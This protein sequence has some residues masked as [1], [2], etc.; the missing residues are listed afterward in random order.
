[1]DEMQCGNNVMKLDRK[2]MTLTINGKVIAGKCKDIQ[3]SQYDRNQPYVYFMDGPYLKGC[4]WIENAEDHPNQWRLDS[5]RQGDKNKKPPW[6]AGVFQDTLT[7]NGDELVLQ[8]EKVKVGRKQGR[9]KLNDKA[10]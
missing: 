6:L 1:M 7:I 10:K 9:R 4:F 5:R 3:T 8:T 2:T